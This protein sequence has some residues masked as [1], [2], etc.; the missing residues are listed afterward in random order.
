MNSKTQPVSNLA[1]LFDE[2]TIIW[3]AYHIK[4]VSKMW[5]KIRD[6]AMWSFN[7]KYHTELIREMSSAD[8]MYR[9]GLNIPAY[10]D[11]CRDVAIERGLI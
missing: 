3:S 5:V 4:T 2:P 11:M 8:V 10:S 9:M 1:K 7:K 6:S